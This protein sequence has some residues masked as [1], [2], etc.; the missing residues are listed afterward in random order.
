MIEFDITWE[1]IVFTIVGQYEEGE[2]ATYDY[3]GS[4]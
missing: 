2:P 4:N 3:P 1:G